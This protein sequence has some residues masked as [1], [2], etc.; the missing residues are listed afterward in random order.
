MGASQTTG[1]V[2]SEVR[3]RNHSSVAA[4]Y[5]FRSR[6][7]TDAPHSL[8]PPSRLRVARGKYLLSLD[9]SMKVFLR[10]SNLPGLEY[11][12]KLAGYRTLAD[13]LNTDQEELEA[14]GFTGI[15]A[16]R[17][18]N[19]VSEYV[20]KQLYRSEEERLPFRLVRKGQRLQTE[21]SESMK[22]NPNFRKRN[23]KRQKSTEGP[24][25]KGQSV[26]N[27]VRREMLA[28]TKI[29]TGQTPSAVRLMTEEDLQLQHLLSTPPAETTGEPTEEPQQDDGQGMLSVVVEEAPPLED[30]SQGMLGDVVEEAPPLEDDSQGM[31]G[32]VVEEAPPLEDD[33]QGMLGDVV[34]EPPL[35]DDSLG[36]LGD[37]VEEAP[38]LEEPPLLE[39]S[40]LLGVEAL[41]MPLEGGLSLDVIQEELEET[42]SPINL[43]FGPTISR[44]F[45]VP[46]D[47][48]LTLDDAAASTSDDYAVSHIRTYSCP[49][50]L[51][52]QLT[53]QSHACVATLIQVLQSTCDTNEL[54]SVL[55][56]L[57]RQCRRK[58]NVVEAASKG[59]LVAVVKI[60][61]KR[62]EVL[63]FAEVCCRLLQHLCRSTS[64]LLFCNTIIIDTRPFKC[65]DYLQ[66]RCCNCRHT[67][68]CMVSCTLY[69]CNLLL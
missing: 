28:V 37:V 61:Q 4:R 35:E 31:L 22:D 68:S 14:R 36:M 56:A 60:L 50:S 39:E 11:R 43:A 20:N 30:D 15:M 48:K 16:Q 67:Y 55:C 21:P 10:A 44:S 52:P 7:E 34:E 42:D 49:P 57:L 47:F 23:L 64:T 17:L 65:R 25:K 9:R 46:A 40:P 51:A 13:L 6:H 62:V 53:Q 24:V 59:A 2:S 45:S 3:G 8:V 69:I 29:P 38:L 54:Y 32:D 5:T 19:A 26:A 27:I 18:M 33:S 41:N 12:L 66:P 1:V 58:Q 63:K